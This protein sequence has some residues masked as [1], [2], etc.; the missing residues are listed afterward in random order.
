MTHHP[1]AILLDLDDTL[2]DHAAAGRRAPFRAMEASGLASRVDP[3]VPLALW[4]ELENQH[5]QGYLDGRISFEEQR[6]R[7]VRDFLHALGETGLDRSRLL[8]WLD[9]YRLAYEQSWRA[10]ADVRPFMDG[11]TDLEEVPTLGVVTN[12]DRAQQAAKMAAL[13]LTGLRLFTSSEVG[14]RK[15]DP[16]ILLHACGALGVAP[17]EAWF[18][19]DN[20]EVD[21]RGADAAGPRGIWLDRDHAPDENAAPPRA[22]SLLDV[23]GWA[24]RPSPSLPHRSSHAGRQPAEPDQGGAREHHTGDG[25]QSPPP[26]SRRRRAP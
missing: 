6:V 15:P 4:R 17:R 26:G 13:E 1:R 2:L 25:E 18:V 7:R 8:D 20:L 11:V 19:G 23:L 21:A 3:A 9:G 10:F 12:G 14:A 24:T 16:A 5:F 22:A